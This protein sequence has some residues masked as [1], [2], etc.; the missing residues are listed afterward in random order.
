MDTA[1]I[2][3]GIGLGSAIFLGLVASFTTA[4]LLGTAIVVMDT[5]NEI[6]K[7]FS[8]AVVLIF[9]GF[10]YLWGSF[11]K[12]AKAVET[13]SPVEMDYFEYIETKLHSDEEIDKARTVVSHTVAAG[14]IM[15]AAVGLLASGVGILIW[16]SL[17]GL[18]LV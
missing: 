2:Y 7:P 13:N 14:I 9:M 8:A 5:I 1:A 6:L 15:V 3:T 16:S 17:N 10:M 4:I 18:D 11:N 12:L